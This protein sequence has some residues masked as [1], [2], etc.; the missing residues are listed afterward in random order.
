MAGFIVDD[1][2][3]EEDYDSRDKKH[4]KK[5]RSPEMKPLDEEDLEV[6]RENVGIDLNKKSR[7]K[8][9]AALEYSPDKLSVKKEDY[10]M[11]DTMPQKP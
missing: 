7:L 9:N 8:R 4:R 1:E 11:I 10:S 2:E 5:R 3:V 6:I